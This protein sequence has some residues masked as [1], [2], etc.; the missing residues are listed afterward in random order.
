MKHINRFFFL[1]I[2]SIPL[3]S[4]QNAHIENY[5]LTISENEK[6][7][8]ENC[9]K[10]E[11]QI[12]KECKISSLGNDSSYLLFGKKFF[13][14]NEHRPLFKPKLFYP[15][16]YQEQGIE[17]FAIAKF[18]ISEE[19]KVINSKIIEGKCGNPRSPF[20]KFTNC[21]GFNIEVLR[22]LKKFEYEPAKFE[23]KNII[24]KDVLHRFSFLMEDDELYIR[25]GKSR[26]Y[27]SVLKAITKK[28]FDKAIDLAESNLE[29]DYMFMTLIA[30]A[31]YQQGNYLD[32]V[33]W[34]NKFKDM[35]LNDQ[36]DI[37]EDIMIRSFMRLISSLFNLQKYEELVKLEPEF[38][39]Y[40]KERK[41]YNELLAMT[42]FY[43][44]VSYINLGDIQKGAYYLGLAAKNS[45]S[46]A[47][48]DYIDTV[49]D[50]ISSY[51]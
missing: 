37:P 7:E 44:G 46:K 41:R 39:N 33:D 24:V 31:K 22:A 6:S 45:N 5:F 43:F 12:Q 50:K 13:H 30:N 51:L 17:G 14:E 49:I 8:I 1:F 32:V 28:N 26:Q 3:Y 35:V 27:N 48:S 38:N 42:N 34:S 25:K 11:K 47:E 29:F 21:K 9:L 4:A 19:G 2:V 15:K 36:R 20:T 40:I 18:D 23:E 10:E 16:R